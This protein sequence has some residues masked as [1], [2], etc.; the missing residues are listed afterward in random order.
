MEVFIGGMME[1]LRHVVSVDITSRRSVELMSRLIDEY[2][3][4][5]GRN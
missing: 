4:N 2:A 3:I 5:L 1:P